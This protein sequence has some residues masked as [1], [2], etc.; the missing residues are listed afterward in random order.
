MQAPADAPR[1]Y[2]ALQPLFRP[3]TVAIIGASRTPGK[4]G[5]TP[6]RN[7]QR[8]A[9][10]GAI[11][12]INPAADEIE[13]LKAYASLR[14]APER[15]DCALMVI[16]S[17]AAVQAMRE[18]AETG[19]RSVVMA[20]TGFS[21][22]GTDEG[23]EREAEIREIARRAGVRIVGPNTNGVFNA[24]HRLPL[25]YNTSHGDPLTPGPVSIA[26]HSGALFNGVAPRL[27]QLGAGLSKYV[28]VG[29][30]ADVTLL[31]LF[32]YYI[33][34]P[35]TG[36][37]GLILEAV[38][39]GPRFCRLAQ[40][41]RNAGKPVVAL[42]LGRSEAGAGATIAHST[43]LAGSAKAYDAIFEEY[44]I[45]AV[46]SVEA[47]AGGCAVLARRSTKRTSTKLVAIA[48]T[49]GGS[50]L[51][52][53]YAERFGMPLAG[54]AGGAWGGKVAAL[55]ATL[56]GSG[57]VR[58]PT[59]TSALGGHD[60]LTPFFKA[61]EADGFDGPMVV[62]T[63]MLP[64]NAMSQLIAKQLVERRERAGSPVVVVAPGGL[65][66]EV[67]E[68]Y[69]AA[70]VPLFQDTDTM[71]HSLACHF[72]ASAPAHAPRAA[73]ADLEKMRPLLEGKAGV[74]SELESAEILRAAGV[75]VVESRTIA[76]AADAVSAAKAFGY[77]VVMKALAP[78]VAH[79]NKLGLVVA[80]LGDE[81]ALTTAH[82]ELEASSA[83][84]GFRR[85]AV[86]FIVQ[87]M[88]R[89]RIE[90]IAGVSF[91]PPF[92]HFLVA[93]LGGVYTEA[94]N[95][96]VLL[97][98]RVSREAMRE[99]LGASR[100]GPVLD[101][102]PRAMDGLVRGLVA[103]QDLVLAHGERIHSVDVNPLLVCDEKADE[104]CVAVD[105]LVVLR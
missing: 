81:R 13:G 29:T 83:R 57:V 21:E 87:P 51:M 78:G 41:A 55:M 28:A 54:E 102:I 76:S 101:S 16:P 105:A 3:R 100:L 10:A 18:C 23:R 85:E 93:G 27:R 84:A 77:P 103:L 63:H 31:D 1:A 34:D 11:Y 14:D 40:E 68:T 47:L 32:E 2:D 71:F 60:R 72:S 15:I 33:D 26:A 49:G 25:G 89:S 52:A 90:L 99:R 53:D 97:P 96:S 50:S 75:P 45:A 20:N 17:A 38:T 95:V 12:P 59:D 22:L 43:R 98:A 70:G 19:V 42:K 8:A 30:E 67:A 88:K 92:G 80:G 5:N 91:E 7:L 48:T 62:Y 66:S 61:Q 56:E 37:I 64:S 94:L 39:D 65:P 46:P 24:S 104:G 44:A 74:L 69:K 6:I 86:T 58:N 35:D 82:A 4:H 73:V 9:F 36:V 79:K